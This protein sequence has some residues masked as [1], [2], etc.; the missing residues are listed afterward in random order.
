[1]YSREE[2]K[3]TRKRQRVHKGMVGSEK[4]RERGK[5][6]SVEVIYGSCIIFYNTA[7]PLL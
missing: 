3:K 7:P 6:G 2:E 1:M 4:L 5:N